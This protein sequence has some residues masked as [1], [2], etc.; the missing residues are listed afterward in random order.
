MKKVLLT[1]MS[2]LFVLSACNEYEELS[3]ALEKEKPSLS[4][5]RFYGV[6]YADGGIET[7]GIAQR[8]K[9]WYP[10]SAITVKFLNGSAEYHDKVKTYASEWETYAGITF[11]FV[12]EGKADARIG[13][14]WNDDRYITWS[15]IGTDCKQVPNQSEA[16]ASFA[17]WSR[18]T[19]EERK[20][21]V[22]RVFGQVLGLELEHRHLN[23]DA[24]WSD[25]IADYWEGEIMDIPWEE[26]KEYVFDPLLSNRVIM[27]DEYD[28][29]SI[30]I[31]PFTR[32]YA[33]NTAR[34][35]NFELSDMDKQFIGQL[36][37][38]G[39]EEVPA[40]IITKSVDQNYTDGSFEILFESDS[41]MEI[42]IDYGDGN[43]EIRVSNMPN[44]YNKSELYIDYYFPDYNESGTYSYTIKIYVT[45]GKI[46]Y[47]AAP[48]EGYTAL[49]IT[50][51]PTIEELLL[52][53]HRL[54][55]LDLTKNTELWF[56]RISD[57]TSW[58][59][60][61]YGLTSLDLSKN[62]KLQSLE[63]ND[64]QITFLDL[65]NNKLLKEFVCSNNQIS[66]LILPSSNTLL[67]I[68]CSNNQLNS[69]NVLE[70]PALNYISISDNP[71][72]YNQS[73]MIN[74]AHSL[75]NRESVSFG[76]I[77]FYNVEAKKWISDICSGKNWTVN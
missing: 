21:D 68:G 63:C 19:E 45:K 60:N 54:S 67:S 20:G 14:D 28:E 32:R 51:C 40:I 37:P 13:F 29:A 22:L 69:L 49:D 74:L 55:S 15:Y 17:D 2:V 50:N 75:P 4:A 36:Y 46:K 35:F 25:R 62:I 10:G 53:R 5:N 73:E 27:T 44:S 1:L 56:L 31:W 61:N 71:I 24:N 64:N 48:G 7:K 23:F 6:K 11:E 59:G 34:E 66:T 41:V 76:T 16:T 8:N 52:D 26:L 18:A 57:C 3:P 38:K 33:G 43:N 72:I 9:L 39:P 12:T 58:Y 65:S 42:K 77:S 47:L 30:M 70:S